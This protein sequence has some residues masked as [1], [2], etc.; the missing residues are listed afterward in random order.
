M[1]ASKQYGILLRR[2]SS[3]RRQ[4]LPQ[5]FSPTGTYKTVELDNARAFQV[6]LHAELEYYFETRAR[7]IS[8]RAFERWRQKKKASRPLVCLVS[9]LETSSPR[10]PGDPTT[11]NAV[12][13]LVGKAVAQFQHTVSHKHGIRKENLAKLFL[14]I[15]IEESAFDVAWLATLDAF[16]SNRGQ[17]AHSSWVTYQIDPQSELNVATIIIEGLQDFDSTLSLVKRTIG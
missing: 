4:Y 7:E 1:A 2:F 17:T 9:N 13:T 14:P 11:K 10:L 15:G 3:L 16:A 6:L 8:D 12:S 5:K